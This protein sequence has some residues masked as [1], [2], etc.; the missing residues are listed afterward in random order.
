[1]HRKKGSTLRPWIGERFGRWMILEVIGSRWAMA[2]CDCGTVKKIDRVS[3]SHGVSKSCGCLAREV[4]SRIKTRHGQCSKMCGKTKEWLTWR[5]VLQRCEDPNS[6]RYDMYAGR[7]ITVCER[8]HKFENF[9]ADMGQA[10]DVNHS[11][12]RIDNNKGY[13]PDNCRWAT[14]KEQ[15]RNRRTTLL[16]S[17]GNTQQSLAAWTEQYQMPYKQV[18]KRIQVYGWKPLTALTTPLKM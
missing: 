8:W 10:P 14:A 1:M 4:T 11:I 3:V 18:W 17:I 13:S 9:F 15:A 6:N 16:I 7:G 5:S 2:R 12:E